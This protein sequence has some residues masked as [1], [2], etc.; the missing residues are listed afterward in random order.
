MSQ[1]RIRSAASLAA[2]AVVL[3]AVAGCG[4]PPKVLVGHNFAGPDKSVKVML[5][6]VGQ[7]NKA[8]NQKVFNVLVRMCDVNAQAETAC[9]D[10]LVLENVVPGSVY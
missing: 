2:F 5:H 6:D 9:K 10:T 1:N 7:T 3:L 4:Q 8:N